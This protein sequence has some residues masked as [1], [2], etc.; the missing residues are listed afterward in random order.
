MAH[1]RKKRKQRLRKINKLVREILI[2]ATAGTIAGTLTEIII[3]LIFR[4]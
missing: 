3:H 1:K 2:G 4:E